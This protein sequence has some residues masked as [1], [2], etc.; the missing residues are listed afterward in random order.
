[1]RKIDTFEYISV[2]RELVESGHEVSVK[3]SG[4]SM[5]PFLRNERDT[6]FFKAPDRALRIGDI[7]FF[8]RANGQYILHRVCRIDDSGLYMLG[9][10]QQRIEGP[11]APEHV[12]AIVTHIDRDGRDIKPGDALWNFYAGPWQW[13]A[14]LRP[15][16]I[17]L[18][19]VVPRDNSYYDK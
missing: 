12:F 5:Y 9:D 16:L 7:A 17:K 10:S 18:H 1:M 11:I 13:L 19:T 4:R 2:L 8:Q 6:V 3:V 14:S 15:R